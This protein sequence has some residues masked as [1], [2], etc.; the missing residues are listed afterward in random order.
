MALN[1]LYTAAFA[2]TPAFV[3]VVPAGRDAEREVAT[4]MK[5]QALPQC[6]VV[7]LLHVAHV[8]LMEPRGQQVTAPHVA[9]VT[10]LAPHGVFAAETGQERLRQATELVAV[11]AGACT[12][13]VRVRRAVA[14]CHAASRTTVLYCKPH[15]TAAAATLR[16]LPGRVCDA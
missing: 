5:L 11:R 2:G 14:L 10:T 4:L 12:C 16:V 6:R 7:R 13:V 8:T 15:R 3:K 9:L 1:R